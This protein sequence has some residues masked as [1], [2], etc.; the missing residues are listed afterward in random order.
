VFVWLAASIAALC[1][2]AYAGD[3]SD[4]D[5]TGRRR[6]WALI[7]VEFKTKVG[8]LLDEVPRDDCAT[9]GR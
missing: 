2:S 6:F 3:S 5:R 9:R 4:G 8:V 7:E 1:S